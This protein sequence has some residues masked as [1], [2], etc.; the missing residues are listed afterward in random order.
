[1]PTPVYKASSP[2]RNTPFR[3]FYLDL[4]EPVEFP[5][6]PDD[7]PVQ[8][9]SRHDRRPDLLASELYGS[10]NFWWVFAV[11]NPNLL[12]DPIE[13]FRTG[14]VIVTPLRQNVVGARVR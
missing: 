12:I 2:Y 1:M 9:Q 4:W 5:A 8:L 10:P 13:D 6:S 11:R 3:D 14:L 7:N